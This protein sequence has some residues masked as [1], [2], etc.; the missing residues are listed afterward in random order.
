MPGIGAAAS[1]SSYMFVCVYMQDANGSMGTRGSPVCDSQLTTLSQQ[2]SV[3]VPS[4]TG[5][6]GQL[7]STQHA[8]AQAEP[9]FSGHADRGD[10]LGALKLLPDDG[11]GPKAPYKPT[12]QE[13]GS[14]HVDDVTISFP[15][16]VQ[17]QPGAAG[18]MQAREQHQV[19]VCALHDPIT[20]SRVSIR[21]HPQFDL[22]ACSVFTFHHDPRITSALYSFIPPPRAEVNSMLAALAMMCQ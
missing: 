9:T 16:T 20:C 12:C 2:S 21:A 15:S 17:M 6:P 4:K 10:M 11:A 19:S 22:D 7:L 3:T 18:A 8:A 13:S 5:T 1:L 14:K